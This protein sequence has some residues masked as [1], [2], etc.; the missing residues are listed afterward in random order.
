MEFFPETRFTF[1]LI[2]LSRRLFFSCLSACRRDTGQNFIDLLSLVLLSLLITSY[3]VLLCTELAC[4]FFVSDSVREDRWS[5]TCFG[6]CRT[7][8]F[9]GTGLGTRKLWLGWDLREFIF[10]ICILGLFASFVR[11]F[12]FVMCIFSCG[13]GILSSW[14]GRVCENSWGFGLGLRGSGDRRR[15]GWGCWEWLSFVR[16]RT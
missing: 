10:F 14:S 2:F 8:I 9:L 13:V 11:F 16:T 1:C 6:I 15:G 3:R 7:H 4:P 5:W 12:V